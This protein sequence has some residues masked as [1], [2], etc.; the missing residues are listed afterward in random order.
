MTTENSVGA[1]PDATM[2][3]QAIN[4]RQ[5]HQNVRRLQ[6]RI[7]KAT[8]EGRWGKVKALQH[9][10]TRSF[11]GRA[12]AVRRVMENQGKR[13][14][15]VDG[16]VWD[17]PKKK[18]EAV[19]TLRQ[20]GYQTLPLRRIYI[21]KNNGRDRRPLS[22]PCLRDRA[23]QA[24][25][26]LALDPIAET[27]ADSNSY[28]FR[29]WRSPADA[30]ERIHHALTRK[31]AAEW[32]LKCDIKSCFDKI[33]HSWLLEHIPMEKTILKKWLKAGFI[34]R[35]T[36]LTTDEGVPQGGIAS[37]VLTNMT[38]D[39]LERTLLRRFPTNRWRDRQRVNLVRFA[40]DILVTGRSQDQLEQEVK[41]VIEKFLAERGLELSSEKTRTIHVSKGFD[42]LGQHIRRYGNGKVLTKP[43]KQSISSLL[44]QVRGVVR[45]NR[46]APAGHLI[47]Q[48]NPI[49]RGWANYHRHAASKRTFGLMDHLI[50]RILWR[51]ARR[52]HPN[53][54]CDW[55]RKKYFHTQGHRNWVFSGIVQGRN[56][57]P[58]TVWLYSLGLTPVKRH[59][60]ICGEANPYD[61]D[62]EQ[63]FEHRLEIQMA[64]K[65]KGYRKLIDLWYE[66]DGKCPVCNQKI[67]KSTGWNSHH[68]IWRSHGGGDGVSNLV[69]LHPVCHKQVHSLGLTVAK[70][71][72]NKG[73]GKA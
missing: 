61:P 63:Y 19:L 48:L 20:R 46:Q 43:A 13:T 66:Q 71:R 67:T 58:Q 4:W 28:G 1:A 37:P 72:P 30:V 14:P 16:V 27:K 39:G 54:S 22:I 69:L 25:Y 51:W 21:P 35:Q 65:L 24:L 33:S 10:L 53:K 9:L 15:G 26:L 5:V 38:L 56:A 40:D 50:F 55:V 47:F 11:S 2:D 73:V 49:L 70:P 8:Q 45:R 23:M 18:I 41:P 12:L 29:Q 64:Q 17:N 6:I 68:I 57:K 44:D 32:I 31:N 52:R 60:K 59:T 3:W 36:L 42:F 7:V 34:D 62:W